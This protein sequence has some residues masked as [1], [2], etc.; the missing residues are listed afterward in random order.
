MNNTAQKGL[1]F[2]EKIWH[3]KGRRSKLKHRMEGLRNF[4]KPHV[5]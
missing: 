5:Q 4:L 2:L 3:F 1:E